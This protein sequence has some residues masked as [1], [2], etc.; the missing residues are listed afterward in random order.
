M[1]CGSRVSI[2]LLFCSLDHRA[3]VDAHSLHLLAATVGDL[4]LG[5]ALTSPNVASHV[6]RGRG[7]EAPVVL[8]RLE[9]DDVELGS[10]V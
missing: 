5:I 7:E 2:C 1:V 4:G 9:D 3:V 8:V 6:F 10:K